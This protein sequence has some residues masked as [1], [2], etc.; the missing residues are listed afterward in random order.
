MV[1]LQMKLKC[2]A[3]RQIPTWESF[4]VHVLSSSSISLHCPK[5]EMHV[6]NRVSIH[7]ARNQCE[8]W[9]FNPAKLYL[10]ILTTTYTILG[11]SCI[12]APKFLYKIY[13]FMSPL[14]AFTF[15]THGSET[16]CIYILLKEKN[17]ACYFQ[18]F[19]QTKAKKKIKINRTANVINF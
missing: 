11:S 15:L 12:I 3:I 2:S 14:P 7:I 10:L 1:Q 9:W 18:L 4:H 8:E 13:L 16:P 5:Y 17:Y 6:G 19:K